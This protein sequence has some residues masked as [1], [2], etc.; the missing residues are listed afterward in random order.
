MSDQL[1]EVDVKNQN[2]RHL[3]E[4]AEENYYEAE[5]KSIYDDQDQYYFQIKEMQLN[6]CQDGKNEFKYGKENMLDVKSEVQASE[7]EYFHNSN[8]HLN[9]KDRGNLKEKQNNFDPNLI[10]N[11]KK[12]L[13][14]HNDENRKMSRVLQPKQPEIQIENAQMFDSELTSMIKSQIGQVE[15]NYS[16]EGSS[17]TYKRLNNHKKRCKKHK[18]RSNRSVSAM[19]MRNKR[20]HI[21]LKI[22]KIVNKEN[23]NYSIDTNS[24]ANKSQNTKKKR[25]KKNKRSRTSKINRAI[26]GFKR[27]NSLNNTSRVLRSVARNK[28]SKHKSV[29]KYKKISKYNQKSDPVTRFQQMQSCWTKH[30]LVREQGR[31]L[32]LE[33]FNKWAQIVQS[34]SQ[35]AIVK[36]SHRY[37]DS[38]EALTNNKRD[39]VKALLS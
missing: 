19:P 22:G 5:G 32:D 3:I 24:K 4:E 2:E 33:G 28:T 12:I 38:N 7:E 30:K 14:K 34:L 39:D 23:I 35:K 36:Q 6:Q 27:T 29:Q 25:V 8:A 1:H 20:N 18:K 21:N 17:G 15:Q 10:Q 9:Q 31:K 37:V 13:E 11:N 26:T 16:I